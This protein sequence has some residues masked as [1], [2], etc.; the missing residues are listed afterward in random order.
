MQF[1]EL[2]TALEVIAGHDLH[3]RC[4]IVTGGAAGIGAE[5]VHALATAGARVIIATR[6]P[7]KAEPVAAALVLRA[8]IRQSSLRL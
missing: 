4:A 5:T 8:A 7:G 3:G 1:T 6:D 2:P